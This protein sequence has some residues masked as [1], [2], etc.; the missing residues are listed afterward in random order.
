MA[1]AMINETINN[2]EE[3]VKGMDS[4]EDAAALARMARWRGIARTLFIL[5]TAVSMAAAIIYARGE[6]EIYLRGLEKR[7]IASVDERAAI[8][9]NWLTAQQSKA[10][11]LMES[12]FF[13][14]YAADVDSYGADISSFLTYDGQ[15][16]ASEDRSEE[17]SYLR[18]QQ[19][20]LERTLRSFVQLNGFDSGRV[21]NRTGQI[22]ISTNSAVISLSGS[23]R[24]HIKMCLD[25]ARPVFAPIY[26]DPNR[27]PMLDMFMP[28]FAPQHSGPVS[29]VVAV[30][31]M[32]TPVSQIINDTMSLSA[33]MA[34]SDT[35][36]LVQRLNGDFYVFN[37]GS[38]GITQL[39]QPLAL[40][41]KQN[42]PFDKRP[43]L[44]KDEDS[45]SLGVK[46]P[47]SD[48]WVV[49]ESASSTHRTVILGAWALAVGLAL[50]ISIV[51]GLLGF[52]GWWNLTSKRNQKMA[53][54]FFYLASQEK[55]QR[56]LLD[57]I[58]A[59]VLDFICL[60]DMD[61]YYTY[62]NASMA[63]TLGQDAEKMVGKTDQDVFGYSTGKRLEVADQQV[64]QSGRA[65]STRET[66][67]IAGKKYEFQ[68]SKV[69]YFDTDNK[70]EG[71]VS[72]FR[73]ITEMVAA[74]ERQNKA[75][76]GIVQAMV[77]SVEMIDPY[78]GG[79]SDRVRILGES[80]A[81]NLNMG[82][83]SIATVK[84]AAN[85]SQLGKLFVDR[86][87]LEKEGVYTEEERIAMR[88][89]VEYAAKI[90]HN[91][92]FSLP[93]YETVYEMNERPDGTGYP[94]G[95]KHDE[96]LPEALVLGVVNTFCAMMRPRSYREG[97][98]MDRALELMKANP[99]QNDPKIVDALEQLIRS[100]LG[101]RV[102]ASLKK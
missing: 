6:Q 7:M 95:L 55:L 70:L 51:V 8:F 5:V 76:E 98:T 65:M 72:V 42:L 29:R 89:H 66:V 69:P 39:P 11:S 96:I 85:L 90:L 44:T 32:T 33:M 81:Q 43:S 87:L 58:N 75:M 102:L 74:Q 14:M 73:D 40:D 30:L 101:D 52:A 26:A 24:E 31:L 25:Q 80:V 19:P 1:Q 56:S 13:S 16:P 36:T 45:Y 77:V 54:E 41:G 48:L 9:N 79:H 59:S 49:Q 62:V 93:I 86:R 12:E 64:V 17:L 53:Q 91:I 67:Y 61:G 27:G 20:L 97:L 88:K 83:D 15:A 68:I 46:L 22:F 23:Q 57:S 38:A 99:G 84:L 10:L 18:D 94:K 4:S 2:M 47:R 21:I 71:I 35:V 100:P 3:I 92:D 60:K 50:L 34:E 28:I 63:R 37:S 82:E 78:L